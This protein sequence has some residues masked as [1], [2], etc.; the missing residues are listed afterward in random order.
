MI[1]N[2]QKEALIEANKQML[3]SR[4]SGSGQEE[5]RRSRK[6]IWPNAFREAK[7]DYR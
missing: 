7:G 2:T 5:F 4:A 6:G 3:N 1:M